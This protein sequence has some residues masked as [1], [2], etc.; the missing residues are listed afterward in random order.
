RKPCN[1]S[2]IEETLVHSLNKKRDKSK[3]NLLT[4][5]TSIILSIVFSIAANRTL[6]RQH[7]SALGD[8]VRAK[9]VELIDEQARVLGTF[10][11]VQDGHGDT[12]PRLVMR[13]SR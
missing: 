3:Q 8:V 10:E 12:L 13:D 1:R 2:L 4:I 11:L 6:E 7:E 5:A 9:R